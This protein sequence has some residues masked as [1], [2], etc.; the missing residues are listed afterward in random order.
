MKKIIFLAFFGVLLIGIHAQKL[1]D[2]WTLDGNNAVS[3][4]NFL[5]TNNNAPLIFKTDGIERMRL[6]PDQLR[7]GIGTDSPNS[8]LHLHVVR[9]QGVTM[10]KLMEITS[11]EDGSRTGHIFGV[12]EQY[13]NL[14]L[15]YKN[16]IPKFFPSRLT[17]TLEDGIVVDAEHSKIALLVN[18]HMQTTGIHARENMSALNADFSYLSASDA[19]ISNTLSANALS[20]RSATLSGALSADNA[21]IIGALSANNATITGALSA[22]L[23]NAPSAKIDGLICAKEVRVQNGSPCWPDFVFAKDYNLLSLAEVEQ[24]IEE[25]QH[26]PNVPSA[27]EV[28][29]N[30]FE[31]GEMNA[32]LL[33]KV[34]ELTLYIIQMEKRLAEMEGKKGGE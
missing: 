29:A 32:I 11:L 28:E 12:Y 27:A 9:D 33:Q 23:L 26:L 17:F 7:L 19:D 22:N 25:N 13:G 21:T 15:G 14:I 16:D 6:L 18:G 24:F 5:G 20:A 30:G 8:P 2:Y 31:L 34:E 1:P 3:N 10:S 4:S